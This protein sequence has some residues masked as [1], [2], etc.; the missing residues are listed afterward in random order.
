MFARFIFA[1]LPGQM[2][3]LIAEGD[4]G[5]EISFLTSSRN[6][7]VPNCVLYKHIYEQILTFLGANVERC[8]KALLLK[9]L[10]FLQWDAFLNIPLK[11]DDNIE[12]TSQS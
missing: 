11:E 8:D 4:Q 2:H 7:K 12:R 10:N 3:L 9:S 1:K 6:I 5:Q